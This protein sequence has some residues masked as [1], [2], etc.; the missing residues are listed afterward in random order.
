[1]TANGYLQIALFLGAVLLLVKP[2]GAY[3]AN[4]YEGR[5]AFVNRFLAPGENLL[6]RLCGVDPA[7][8][9]RWTQYALAMLVFNLFGAL[10][11]YALQRLQPDLPLNPQGFGAVSPDSSFNTAVSFATNTNWQG[12]SGETTM[13]YLTQMAA[14]TVQNFVSAASGMAVL[15][16]LIRGFARQSVE[17]LGNFWVDLTRGTLYVL[18][19]L[20]L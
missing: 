10:A 12:Y 6:Y 9:M 16:A 15:I 20:S 2:L 4:V 13:S 18:L 1:M 17:T 8:E 11:V 5:V 14:L 7:Q 19:P 3:M